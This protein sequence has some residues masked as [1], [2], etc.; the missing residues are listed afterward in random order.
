MTERLITYYV[1][2]TS[3]IGSVGVLYFGLKLYEF[4]TTGQTQL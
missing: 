3:F 1:H 2:G 4:M